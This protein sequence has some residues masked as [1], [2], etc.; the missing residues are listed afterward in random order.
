[1]VGCT[2][3][4]RGEVLGKRNLD[5]LTTGIRNL[6]PV[7][8]DT[9]ELTKLP[10]GHLSIA[11]VQDVDRNICQKNPITFGRTWFITSRAKMLSF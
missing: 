9:K 2:P 8:E 1:M 4:S 6:L 5:L 11:Y 3:G 7:S 10:T